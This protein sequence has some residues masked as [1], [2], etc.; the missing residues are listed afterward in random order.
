MRVEKSSTNNC[1]SGEADSDVF[2]CLDEAFC[3]LLNRQCAYSLGKLR[4]PKPPILKAEC[5]YTNCKNVT[6]FAQKRIRKPLQ[7][8]RF[9][10]SSL[11]LP[12]AAPLVLDAG[13]A[14]II[15]LS[16]GSGT[17]CAGDSSPSWDTPYSLHPVKFSCA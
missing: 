14:G 16:R 2:F 6:R 12:V 15:P 13:M 10:H 8:R 7:P 17:T 4:C 3:V 9:N 11:W 1:K 5:N